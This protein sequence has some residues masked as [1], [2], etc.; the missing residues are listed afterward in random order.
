MG[1]SVLLKATNLAKGQARIWPYFLPYGVTS[2]AS[3][4]QLEGSPPPPHVCLVSSIKLGKLLE[5]AFWCYASLTDYE[6]FVGYVSITIVISYEDKIGL[7]SVQGCLYHKYFA[8]VLVKV[9][10]FS[11]PATY[12]SLGFGCQSLDLRLRE[13]VHT[14]RSLV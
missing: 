8:C 10:L 11:H 9:V 14:I 3:S 1:L 7:N 5:L 4:M 2:F 13:K 6:P 12:P